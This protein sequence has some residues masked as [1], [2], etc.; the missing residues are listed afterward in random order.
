MKH[1]AHADLSPAQEHHALIL[2]GSKIGWHQDRLAAWERG[3][4]FAPITI[5][6]ALT[7]KCQASCVFCYAVLQENDRQEITFPVM[8]RFLSDCADIGVRGISLVSDGESTM[9]PAFTFTIRRGHELGIS[10]ANGT[11]GYLVTPEVA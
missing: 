1:V 2:D 4:R 9:S 7:R 10:M 3:E 11:N 6:M 8:E 5:D